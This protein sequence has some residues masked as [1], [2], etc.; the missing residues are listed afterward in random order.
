MKNRKELILNM[1][2]IEKLRPVDIAKKLSISKSAVTQILKKDKRYA[3]IKSDRKNKNNK[4]HIRKTISYINTKRE[5]DR[6]ENEYMKQQ[7][8]QASSELSGGRKPISNIA[9]R[10]WNTSVYKYNAKTKNYVLDKDITAGAD[11]PKKIKW[12]Y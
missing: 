12:Y 11:I 9:Y 1:Y 6:I 4:N 8:I 2:F 5:I 10:D 7:H 3:Q